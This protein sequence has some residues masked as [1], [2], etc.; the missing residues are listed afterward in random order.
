[1]GIADFFDVT[2]AAAVEHTKELDRVL[3]IP[4]RDPVAL[5]E[6]IAGPLSERL[7]KSTGT[8]ALR[9]LQALGLAEA[10][11]FGGLL[12]L[13]PVGEGKT[14]LTYLL[15][16][17]LEAERPVLIV[18]AALIMKTG[19]E[20]LKLDRH[21]PYPAKLKV[22]AFEW[23]SRQPDLLNELAPDLLI[24]D[25]VH[26]LKNPKSAVT[27]RVYRYLREHDNTRFCGL[28][29]TIADRSF[30]DWW[31]IVQWCLP[32]GLQPLPIPY[33]TMREWAE[34]LDEKIAVRR[35]AGALTAFAGNTSADLATIRYAF[36]ARLRM[37]P[38]I[39][40][41][42]APD[43]SAS[44]SIEIEDL[45]VPALDEHLDRL[46]K[47]WVTPDGVEFSEATDLWRHAREL[48]NGFY[49]RWD[50]APP[51]AWMNA[52]TDFHRFVRGVLSRSRKFDTVS[53]VAAAFHDTPVVQ[54]WNKI[55]DS[56]RPNSVPVWLDDS[57]I[58]YALDWA[59]EMP[60]I[61]WCEHTA[62]GERLQAA[63]L[64]YFG[65]QGLSSTGESIDTYTGPCAASV[66]ACRQG[67]NLQHY[68]ASLI[69]NC[70]PKGSWYEQ[71]LGRMH[72]YGQEADN[73]SARVLIV[74][75]EQQA[76]FDQAVADAHYIEQTTGQRQKLCYADYTGREPGRLS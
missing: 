4:Q 57:V 45:E 40:A 9:P 51:E 33:N 46:R 8:M 34:A 68:N 2:T 76:G 41:T 75:P 50:P 5:S 22:I 21:W 16:T 60:G 69:L 47:L 39:I 48:A 26:K 6:R 25:E 52:R 74:C 1:M 42:D 28:S 17:V 11:D 65:E 58:D 36:G 44:L 64:P 13:L 29:G 10:H 56:F 66:A 3:H 67:F 55:K 63:G 31:H 27:K 20:F 23:I 7:R 30:M 18:P 43:V 38:G 59:G 53:Q 35:P 73:V 15:P 54:E 12:A 61:V 71:L 19:R 37:T 70:I 49:Y 14:L 24:V 32:A 62:V 72:R